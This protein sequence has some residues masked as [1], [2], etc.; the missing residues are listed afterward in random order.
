[1]TK[2]LLIVLF[3]VAAFSQNHHGMVTDSIGTPIENAYIFN[4]VSKAHA[5][6]N[7]LGVFEIDKTNPGDILDISSPG[8]KKTTYTVGD[9]EIMIMM[10]TDILK[11]EQV[12]VSS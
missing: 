6:T 11:L 9:E 3:S 12:V 5:H 7:E 4:I 1:M 2:F 10:D 8:F